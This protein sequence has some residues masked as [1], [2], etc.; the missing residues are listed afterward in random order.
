MPAAIAGAVFTGRIEELIYG[1]FQQGDEL[2]KGVE[3]GMLAPV[4]DIHDGTRSTVYKLC[5]VFLCPALCLSF[6]LDLFAKSMKIKPSVVLVHFHLTP[7]LFYISGE[8][9]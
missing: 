5:E 3:A 7:I 8:D 6:S 9:I 1:N 2:I 4:F